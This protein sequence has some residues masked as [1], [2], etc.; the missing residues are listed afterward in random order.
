ML[1][2]MV[3]RV[4]DTLNTLIF[5]NEFYPNKYVVSVSEFNC[6]FCHFMV[7]QDKKAWRTVD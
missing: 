2:V 5:K 7:V 4:L 3:R 1:G 6:L